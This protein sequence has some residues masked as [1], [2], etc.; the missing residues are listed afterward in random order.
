M[1]EFIGERCP[2]CD[3]LFQEEDDIVVCPI[4]G[5]PHHRQCY[6]VENKCANINYHNEKKEW[7]PENIQQLDEKKFCPKCN[8]Q[9]HINHEYC[10]SCGH[11][12]TQNKQFNNFIHDEKSLNDIKISGLG[13]QDFHI[14]LGRNQKY[15]ITKFK[16]Y[17]HNK[18]FLSFNFS[19]F[20]FSFL[21]YFYRKMYRIG[22]II[23]ALTILS[24]V[25]VFMLSVQITPQIMENMAQ[26]IINPQSISSI[27]IDFT[28]LE[29]Q[30]LL[31]NISIKLP[32][33]I[34]LIASMIAN[35]LYRNKV[36]KDISN[37]KSQYTNDYE[38]NTMLYQKGGVSI[39]NALAALLLL[40]S[41]YF[42]II[43]II[44]TI[45]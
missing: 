18:F 42:I 31:A 3:E 39:T 15:F 34:S 7:Q 19:A 28:G 10:I 35:Y 24:F 6:K 16:K 33:L 29:G 44:S 2:V 32:F 37:I 20:I 8:S 11:N 14:Y 23:L 13:L 30:L 9:N 38:Y 12:F 41:I 25:P 36:I 45:L 40:F 43:S 4:C 1:L 17:E 26:L 22:A 27:N 5:T 21:Y